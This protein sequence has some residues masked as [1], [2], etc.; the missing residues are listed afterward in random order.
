VYTDFGSD[1]QPTEEITHNDIRIEGHN[2]NFKIP[3]LH[4]FWTEK[5]EWLIS[6][7]ADRKPE[8]LLVGD[9]LLQK[10]PLDLNE[11]TSDFLETEFGLYLEKVD[12][13]NPCEANMAFR[14][15]K[16]PTSK[17]R[18][19]PMKR[20]SYRVRSPK[21]ILN[22]LRR[23]ETSSAINFVFFDGQL[24]NVF[25][26]LDSPPYHDQFLSMIF[27]EAIW[28][29]S[30]AVCILI[31]SLQIYRNTNLY[32]HVQELIS[33]LSEDFEILGIK[34]L[35]VICY[36]PNYLTL[37]RDYVLSARA[38]GFDFEAKSTSIDCTSL[39]DRGRKIPNF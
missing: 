36:P 21:D 31:C 25:D 37:N 5:C 7:L 38:E 3:M 22:Q 30:R 34:L 4:P 6:Y 11:T 1:A 16:R 20:E 15:P 28:A 27:G 29:E 9:I 13:I 19:P 10:V 14:P 35:D 18:E 33:G 24:N 32:R 12:P 23:A 39:I 17:Q 2:H 26:S 8:K